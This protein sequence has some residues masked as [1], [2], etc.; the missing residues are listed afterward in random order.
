MKKSRNRVGLWQLIDRE[1][2]N[3][4]VEKWGMD[5]GVRSFSTWEMCCTLM[6]CMVLRLSSYRDTQA[7]LQVPRSTLSD[8][9]AERSYGFFQDLCDQTLLAIKAK[10][11]DRKSRRS[12]RRILALDSSECRVHGSLFKSPRWKQRQ[13][14]DRHA[15][16]VKLHVMWDVDGE[17]VEDFLI[18]PSRCNDAPVARGFAI[19]AGNFYVFD[20]A[21]CAVSFWIKIKDHGSHFV[22]RLKTN[23]LNREER[24]RIFSDKV[25]VL[26]D[27]VYQPAQPALSRLPLEQRHKAKFR[28]IV[29]RIPKNNKVLRLV[30]SDFDS[31]AEEIAEIYKQRWD[32]ELLFRWLKGYLNIRYLPTKNP[33]AI[34][35]QLAVAVLLKLLIQ[36]KKVTDAYQGPLSELLRNLRT[37]LAR[38]GINRSGAPPGCRWSASPH[39]PFRHATS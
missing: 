17:W 13:V 27:G 29:Y 4:L 38:D 25:G 30:T 6:N 23:M 36:L 12:I 16:S 21:Y 35:T 7:V 3:D 37:T 32:V 31:S 18:A 2:F 20:R 1:N 10:S 22:T 34:K 39:S 9:L 11:R 26:H 14:G 15:A 19:N 8:A 28:H 24:V 5:K 33:N